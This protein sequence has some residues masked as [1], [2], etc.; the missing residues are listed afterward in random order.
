MTK[1][2]FKA[3]VVKRGVIDASQ[4]LHLSIQRQVLVSAFYENLQLDGISVSG[5]QL[6]SCVFKNVQAR[7]V[8]LGAGGDQSVYRNCVFEHCAFEVASAGNTRLV[9]CEFRDCVL[10]RVIG[11]ALEVVGCKFPGSRIQSAV[12]Y[13]ALPRSRA[14]LSRRYNEFRDNDFSGTTFLDTSFRGGIDLN[15]Q[16]LPTG[17]G[18]LLINDIHQAL[19]TGEKLMS[20]LPET[21]KRSLKRQMTYLTLAAKSGQQ[22]TLLLTAELGALEDEW[23]KLITE[24]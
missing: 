3:S 5:S 1:V 9:G 24:R 4:L 19:A 14:G 8:S 12:F 17:G 13:G 22:S 18:Y 10:R 23:R 2:K 20:S 16:R 6:D 15:A 21:E 11:N 7:S